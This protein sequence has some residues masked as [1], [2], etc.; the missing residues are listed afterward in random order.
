MMLWR[1]SVAI[2]LCLTCI[3]TSQAAS[4]Q[5]V[6]PCSKGSVFT[7]TEPG[8][9]GCDGLQ[10]S[11][12]GYFAH[13]ANGDLGT[14]EQLTLSGGDPALINFNV[15]TESPQR[16]LGVLLQ[17]R[18]NYTYG[19]DLTLNWLHFHR[20]DTHAIT[21]T[22][23]LGRYFDVY[24]S[25]AP[26][27]DFTNMISSVSF[28]IDEVNLMFGQ[29]IAFDSNDNIRVR[30]AVG[31]S[32]VQLDHKLKTMGMLPQTRLEDP[33]P[34]PDPP[35]PVEECTE[36]ENDSGDRFERCCWVLNGVELDCEI[37]PLVTP[38][39]T[40][41][42]EGDNHNVSVTNKWRGVGIRT[43][44][45]VIAALGHGIHLIGQCNAA[46]Y[47]GKRDDELNTIAREDGAVVEQINISH[48][49]STI[50]PA[51]EMRGGIAYHYSGYN[52]ELGWQFLHFWDVI[53]HNPL[54]L[55]FANPPGTHSMYGLTVVQAVNSSTSHFSLSGPYALFRLIF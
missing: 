54:D 38:L 14:F 4:Y 28:A 36:F 33:D 5:P 26:M 11:I 10:M 17:V 21:P 23:V 30:G 2:L 55:A 32:Y 52:F 51:V 50:T 46:L 41:P 45:G 8:L 9:T 37:T 39:V 6:L 49:E 13:G 31:L 42:G 35:E 3:T 48:E 34:P 29:E 24:F 44:V 40:P 25:M 20:D 16:Q 1:V 43:G 53:Q 27:T 15:V 22:N 19:Q 18:Q 47:L 7:A 12:M